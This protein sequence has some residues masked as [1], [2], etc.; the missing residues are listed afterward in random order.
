MYQKH[1]ELKNNF[2]PS[3]DGK[4]KKEQAKEFSYKLIVQWLDN[5]YPNFISQF[6][7][8]VSKLKT[9]IFLTI[10]IYAFVIFYKYYLENRNPLE[11]SEFGDLFHLLY[12]PYCKMAIMEKDICDKLNQIKRNDDSA[13]IN[14]PLCAEINFFKNFN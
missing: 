10:N 12:I 1:I 6:K 14:Y 9:N 7:R 3:T 4:Y 13:K 11:R 5:D 8:D 2:P